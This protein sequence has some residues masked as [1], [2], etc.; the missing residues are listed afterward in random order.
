MILHPNFYVVTSENHYNK[1]LQ[2]QLWDLLPNLLS[3]PCDFEQSFPN[4]AEILG[5]ALH[6]QEDIRLILLSSLRSS[7]RFSL[8]PDAT[9]S[10][11][12]CQ[13]FFQV[14]R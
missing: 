8:E 9:E 6:E 12:V 11:K 2:H 5:K 10:R 7:I 3:S 13:S 14:L 4:L 1:R